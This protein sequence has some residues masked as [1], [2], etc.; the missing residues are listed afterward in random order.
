MCTILCVRPQYCRVRPAPLLSVRDT[1]L[2]LAAHHGPPKLVRL[3]PPPWAPRERPPP[4]MPRRRVPP[5]IPGGSPRS[6]NGR[7]GSHPW[8]PQT[9]SLMGVSDPMFNP[10]TTARVPPIPGD[11]RPKNRTMDPVPNVSLA[12]KAAVSNLHN[13][14]KIVARGH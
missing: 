3:P 13:V 8:N 1:T 6:Q 12:Q 7:G 9:A 4:R 14:S 10:P 11:P 5:K 2:G